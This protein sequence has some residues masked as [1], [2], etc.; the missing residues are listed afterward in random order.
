MR[1]SEER[2]QL[3][4]ETTGNGLWDW[5]IPT[6]ETYYS[7]GYCLMLGLEP[8]EFPEHFTGWLDLMHPEDREHA[9]NVNQD[10]IQGKMEAFE[11]EFRMRHKDGSWRWI[12]G[13]GKSVAR[14][15]QGMAIRLVG[16]HADI[17]DRKK[18]EEDLRRS[19]ER[20]RSLID[21]AADAIFVHDFNGRFLEVNQQACNALG[22]TRDELLSMSVSDVDPDAVHR[23]DRSKFWPNLSYNL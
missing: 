3:A 20:F 7:Q 11:V 5:D 17:T 14:D 21:Q 2:L 10:C 18:A 13:R 16:T 1:V 15:A 12:L 23:G 9:W 8:R 6:G 4:M 19:E 22:Y